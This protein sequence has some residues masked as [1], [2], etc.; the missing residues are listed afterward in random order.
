[1]IPTHSPS[2][3]I[4]TT[5]KELETR[6]SGQKLE[7]Q[8]SPV[9][10]YTNKEER[11]KQFGIANDFISSSE[12]VHV[13][14]VNPVHGNRHA[15]YLTLREHKRKRHF[16]ILCMDQP[17]YEDENTLRYSRYESTSETRRS[18]PQHISQ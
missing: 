13:K 7:K 5:N 16:N 2:P 10:Y 6:L 1:M 11:T 15:P 8:E 3:V 9:D 14:P 12:H 18:N 4:N 17:V